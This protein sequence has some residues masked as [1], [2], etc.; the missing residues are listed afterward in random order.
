M[1]IAHA[2]LSVAAGHVGH[3]HV[4]CGPVGEGA[5]HGEVSVID[6]EAV[7]RCHGWVG[8]R[9]HPVGHA[10]VKQAIR[11]ALPVP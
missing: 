2:T 3:G 10:A 1:G 8:W 6:V 4:Q 11:P 9:Q 7:R 5:L